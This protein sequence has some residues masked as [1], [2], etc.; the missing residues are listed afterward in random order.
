MLKFIKNHLLMKH[1]SIFRNFLPKKINFFF[2]I[3]ICHT[4]FSQTPEERSIIT[5]EYDL[6]KITKHRRGVI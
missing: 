2:L 3:F 4:A 5:K 6:I 1:F